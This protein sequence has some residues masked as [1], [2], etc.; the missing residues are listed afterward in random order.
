MLF[1]QEAEP[2]GA[3]PS[4]DQVVSQATK[5]LMQDRAVLAITTTLRILNNGRRR[6]KQRP[7]P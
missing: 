3:A 6:S 7:N 5:Y 1:T 2:R 4:L